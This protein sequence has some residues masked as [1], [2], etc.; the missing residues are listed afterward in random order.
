MIYAFPTDTNDTDAD[1]TIG[2]VRVGPEACR[3]GAAQSSSA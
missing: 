2:A 3:Q 1:I